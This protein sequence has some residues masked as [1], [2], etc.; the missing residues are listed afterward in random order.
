[1]NPCSKQLS[2]IKFDKSFGTTL[3]SDMAVFLKST[4]KEFCDINLVLDGNEVIPAHKTILA[5]RCAY[6]QAM[7]GY[8]QSLEHFCILIYFKF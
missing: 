2:D 7:V 6:F 3:E 4:G 1:L 8:L 5:A